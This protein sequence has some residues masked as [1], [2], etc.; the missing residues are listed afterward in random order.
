MFST[1]VSVSV[2][3]LAFLV[4]TGCTANSV[5]TI[6]EE[7]QPTNEE[8]GRFQ[9]LD[10]GKKSYPLTCKQD[11]YKSRSDDIQCDS[12]GLCQYTGNKKSPSEALDFSVKW[13]G[14]ATF[15]IKTPAGDS[16]LTDPVFDEFDW[17]INWL[18]SLDGEQRE[19]DVESAPELIDATDAI[20]YSHVHYDHFNKSDIETIGVDP[21]YLVPLNMADHFPSIG[22]KIAEI[23][24]FSSKKIGKTLVTAVPAHH[25]SSRTF[26]PFIY[27]DNNKVS[28]NAWLVENEGKKL[29]FAGDTGYSE[30]FKVINK[31]YGD[32]DVCLL[33]I[34]SYYSKESPEWYRYVHMTP[35][36]ALTAADD[37]NCKILIPWGYGNASWGMGDLSSH[38]ALVRFLNIAERIGTS[39]E[40]VILNEGESL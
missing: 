18:F 25:F 10:T 27:E 2:P 5:T 29:F 3:T 34:A 23:G 31:R 6:I 38:S 7:S 19:I 1:G 35:E 32:I 36:D 11:C 9:N 15:V 39:A 37:L 17:P 28:W 33:P 8:T 12:E 24:W 4:L 30:H 14:H 26:V 16:F 20:L 21:E 22:A 13:L 40:I